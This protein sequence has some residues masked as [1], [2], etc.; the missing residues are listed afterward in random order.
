MA[1]KRFTFQEHVHPLRKRLVDEFVVFK[2]RGSKEK[3]PLCVGIHELILE[4]LPD[5]DPVLLSLCLKDYTSGR[6]YLLKLKEGAAR[7][8]AFG[9]A[10]GYVDGDEAR[11]AA[12]RLLDKEKEYQERMA[13]MRKTKKPAKGAKGKTKAKKAA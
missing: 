13:K 3:V 8:N 6:E 5:I 1:K 2:E 10:D 11:K 7:Y 9:Q 4:E 12:I